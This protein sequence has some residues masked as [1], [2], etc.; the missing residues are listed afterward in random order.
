MTA[1]K[2]AGKEATTAPVAGYRSLGVP[3]EGLMTETEALGL[4][5]RLL[6][7][8]LLVKALS[9]DPFVDTEDIFRGA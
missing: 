6:L 9:D 3:F 1:V 7:V 2:A 4:F 8:L 5:D